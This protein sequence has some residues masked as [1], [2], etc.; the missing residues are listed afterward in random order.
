[1]R[2]RPRPQAPD[3]CRGVQ[4]SRPE[5]GRK[6]TARRSAMGNVASKSERR[7]SH[8]HRGSGESSNRLIRW[9]TWLQWK[10]RRKLDEAERIRCRAQIHAVMMCESRHHI[11]T[12]LRGGRGGGGEGF[13]EGGWDQCATVYAHHNLLTPS[14]LTPQASRT[15]TMP[16]TPLI[17]ENPLF[18]RWV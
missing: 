2:V 16:T 9:A 12:T 1:M 4:W 14:A 13:P 10:A 7:F 6:H 15:V 5:S 3:H 11:C 17:L 18:M 8:I